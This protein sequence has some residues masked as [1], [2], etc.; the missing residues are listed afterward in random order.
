MGMVIGVVMQSLV[1]SYVTWKTDWD[2]EVIKSNDIIYY[3]ILHACNNIN[4]LILLLLL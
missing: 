4:Y 1:L 3:I 2:E